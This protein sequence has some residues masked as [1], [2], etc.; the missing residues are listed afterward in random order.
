MLWPG[1]EMF[2][3]CA[4]VIMERK[5]DEVKYCTVLIIGCIIKIMVL[6]STN[7]YRKAFMDLVNV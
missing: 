6:L 1:K 7:D 3:K 5:K 4:T 2:W